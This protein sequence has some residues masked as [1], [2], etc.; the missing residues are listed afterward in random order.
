MR[1]W[2]RTVVTLV[3]SQTVIVTDAWAIENPQMM[4]F[5]CRETLIGTGG[6]LNP[7][8]AI[9]VEQ[10]DV[11][12]YSGKTYDGKSLV[13]GNLEFDD[14]FELLDA[15]IPL[16]IKIFHYAEPVLSSQA[17]G[18]ALFDA[19]NESDLFHEVFVVERPEVMRTTQF[20]PMWTDNEARNCHVGY[21]Y[22]REDIRDYSCRKDGKLVLDKVLSCDPAYL[23]D[24]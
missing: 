18:Q 21:T 13:P 22:E 17:K 11:V 4:Q 10:T 5:V 12:T 7:D 14:M 6:E 2:F 15:P 3:L 1:N 8:F 24:Q 20:V 9:T 16:R 23:V 19:L